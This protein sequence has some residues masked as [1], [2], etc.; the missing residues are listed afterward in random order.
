[1]E[2]ETILEN[3]GADDLEQKRAALAEYYDEL[4]RADEA[5][6]FVNIS[7][8]GLAGRHDIPKSV[9]KG[10]SASI[11]QISVCCSSN[12]NKYFRFVLFV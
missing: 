7:V 8:R 2:R 12:V 9:F 11:C 1:M 3:S 10:L 4:R 6:E 5:D